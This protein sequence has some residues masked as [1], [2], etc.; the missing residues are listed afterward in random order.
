MDFGIAGFTANFLGNVLPSPSDRTGTILGTVEFMAPEQ[1]EE[2]P[3]SARSEIYSMGCIFYYALTGQ[4]PF[5]GDDAD[6]ITASHLEARIVPLQELRPDLPGE[7]CAWVMRLLSRR[8]ESRPASVA[9][10]LHTFR[11]LFAALP[12]P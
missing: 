3:V 11:E 8:P 1:F 12:A 9:E 4:D 2:Q 6:A 7:V 5:G 10:A